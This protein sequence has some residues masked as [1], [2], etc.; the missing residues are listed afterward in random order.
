MGRGSFYGSLY[1]HHIA[2]TK[3]LSIVAIFMFVLNGLGVV[4][5]E[6]RSWFKMDAIHNYLDVQT[7]QFKLPGEF[8]LH[9]G[10]LVNCWVASPNPECYNNE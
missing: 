10:A 6:R 2:L 1:W 8:L 9:F 4:I 5:D 3:V 7:E